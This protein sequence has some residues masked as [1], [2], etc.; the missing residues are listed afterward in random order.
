MALEDHWYRRTWLSR[1]LLPVAWLFGALTACRRTL[2]RRGVIRTFRAPVPVIV[3][4]NLSVGG[5]GKTPL[6]VYLARLLDETGYRVGVVSRG[7]GGSAHQPMAV[8]VDSAPQQTG[9][10][11]LLI[12]R[13]CNAPV[14]VGRNRPRAVAAL[15]AA[16]PCDVVLSDDGLQHYALHRDVEIVVVDTERGMGNGWLLPAGPLRE[17]PARLAQA[18]LVVQHGEAPDAEYSFELRLETARNLA[19]GVARRL[20]DFRGEGVHAVA[21]IGHPARFFAQLKRLG[22]ACAE[23]P[24]PDHHRFRAADLAFADERPV[25]MTEKDAVKCAAFAAPHWWA[26]PAALVDR[27]SRIGGAVR[28]LLADVTR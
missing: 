26:V 16:D 1:L 25:L 7:H 8:S 14:W 4:G 13:S 12:A 9:D 27:D 21:G 3:V 10:E 22:I 11:A 6:V 20:A 17:P 24:F 5:T 28:R 2:Y 23:H 19:S 15:L 18:D